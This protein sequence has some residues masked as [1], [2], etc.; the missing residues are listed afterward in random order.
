MEQRDGHIMIRRSGGTAGPQGKSCRIALPTSWVKKLGLDEGDHGVTLQFD[1]EA[2]TIRPRAAAGYDAFL[3]ASQD[4]GHRILLLYY[5]DDDK[6]CTKICADYTAHDLAIENTV[7]DPLQTAFGV[8]LTPN[9]S[10]YEDFL[11]HRCVPRQR[12]GL[13]QYLSGIGL[14]EYEPLEIIRKTQG[15]MAEDMFRLELREG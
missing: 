13:R 2:I 5:Y 6:L 9:W 4:A 7:D 11:E 3:R 14:T 15:R 8:N 1:G 12:Y 10:E